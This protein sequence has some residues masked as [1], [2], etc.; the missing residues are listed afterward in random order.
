M[1]SL[2]WRESASLIIAAGRD[3]M[4][5]LMLQRGAAGS[6]AKARVF[7]GG[8]VESHDFSERWTHLFRRFF[9]NIGKASL[10]PEGAARAPCLVNR[11]GEIA[12]EIGM[13]ITAIRET[14]EETGILF[15]QPASSLLPIKTEVASWRK[16][17]LKDAAHFY[18]MCDHHSIYPDVDALAIWS[19]WLTPIDLSSKRF[20]TVFF[21]AEGDDAVQVDVHRDEMDMFEWSSP[22]QSLLA[23]MERKVKMAPPQI[24]ELSRL[25]QFESAKDLLKFAVERQ[26]YGCDLTLPVRVRCSDGIVA[27]FPGDD[28]YPAEPDIYGKEPVLT[29]PKTAEELRE[30]VIRLHRVESDLR[31]VARAFHF[32]FS[33]EPQHCD[34]M[35][36]N[37]QS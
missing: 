35:P 4:K 28:S 22:L 26:K 13:R 12:R 8:V 16:R 10:I 5:I 19:D 34:P 18:D 29:S 17:V 20:D 1:V 21:V 37:A 14:F 30:G 23:R 32:N 3:P 2:P 36:F 15:A 31:D 9:D 25:M 33:L 7:P 27:I 24:Y 11:P 6:F